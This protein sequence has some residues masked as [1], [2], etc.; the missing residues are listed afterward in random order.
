MYCR[1][2]A[3]DLACTTDI[4]LTTKDTKFALAEGNAAVCS[5]LGP[6]QRIP[7]IIG[8][9]S[10]LRE[11]IFTCREF[12]GTEAL[13]KG[14]VSH[15]YDT[16]E[17]LFEEARKIAKTIASKSP[18]G[19]V[20]AKKTLLYARDHSVADGLAQIK[21]WNAFHLMSKDVGIALKGLAEGKTPKFDSF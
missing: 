9:E 6:Y 19:I 8:N 21:Q 15:A 13:E 7:K 1:G 2:T 5:D 17:Q 12:D 10:W 18:I 4:R 16:K 11:V 3:M 20:G 14:F